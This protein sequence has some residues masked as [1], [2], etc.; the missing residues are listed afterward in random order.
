MARQIH[1]LVERK[2]LR[3]IP[4]HCFENTNQKERLNLITFF[5]LYF[6]INYRYTNISGCRWLFLPEIINE[7]GAVIHSLFFYVAFFGN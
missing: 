6:L 3:L 1:R 2:E 4:E 7:P 5:L